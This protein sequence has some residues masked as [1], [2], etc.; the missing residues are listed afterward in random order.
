MRISD[1]SLPHPVLGISDDVKGEFEVISQIILGRDS[2]EIKLEY[3]LS[4]QSLE[5]LIAEDNAEFVTEISCQ[6]TIFRD[7]YKTKSNKQEFSIDSELLRDDV[8]LTHW[9]V[10]SSDIPDYNQTNANEDY[11]GSTFNIEKGDVLAYGKAH[12]FLA[13]KSWLEFMSVSSFMLIREDE[14]DKGPARY[15]LHNHQIK[16]WLAKNDFEKYHKSRNDPKFS[17]IF[18]SAIVLPALIYALSHIMSNTETYIDRKWYLHLMLRMENDEEL[19]NTK[20]E[21]DMVPIIAQALL[22]NPLDRTFAGIDLLIEALQKIQQ[23]K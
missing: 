13:E 2:I 16:I 20:R 1:L 22:K 6:E 15:D 23:D 4:N 18:H 5:D 8:E 10:A 17:P 19:R 12:I 14:R 21:M 3:S 11:S 7:A 9:I